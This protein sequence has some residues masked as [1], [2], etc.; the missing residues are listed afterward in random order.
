MR[1]VPRPAFPLSL[2]AVLVAGLAA[3]GPAAAVPAVHAR[4]GAPVVDGVP[5]SGEATMSA[6]RIAWR[7]YGAV[8]ELDARVT[9]DGVPV[10]LD[11]P[12]LDRTT[13][14]SGLLARR[15]AEDLAG[16]PV[17]VLGRPGGPLAAATSDRPEPIP[18]LAE[19]LVYA[20]DSGATVSLEIADRAGEPGFDPARNAAGRVMDAVVASGLPAARLIVRSAVPGDLDVARQRLPGV[21][22]ALVTAAA[23]NA[24]GPALAAGR[25]DAWLSPEWPV[26]AAYVA[27]A[28]GAGRLV[29]PAVLD[30]PA[31]V[32][33]GAALAVDAIVT[34]DLP[35]A[36]RALGL[37]ETAPSG[38][39][40][41]APPRSAGARPAVRHARP[42]TPTRAR[43]CACAGAATATP[44]RRHAGFQAAVRARGQRRAAD[45][46]SA[47]R[48]G[49]PPRS[50]T[51]TGRARAR[52]TTSAS[53]RR[54]RRRPR[55][56]RDRP[57]RRALRRPRQRAAALRL[58]AARASPGA[59]QGAVRVAP[60]AGARHALTFTGRALRV[61]APLSPD[62]GRLQ[63]VLDGR[64][65][66]VSLRGERRRPPGRVRARGAALRLPPRHAALARR[67]AGDRRRGRPR[68]SSRAS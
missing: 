66:T 46:R 40:P 62:G 38:Q 6:L 58:L 29:A 64:R 47:R 5:T 41:P 28:H 49:A 32:Q 39:D 30:T 65:R 11:D 55:P 1:R 21:A 9:A 8:L 19:A 42:A 57:L 50:A 22:T 26:D 43:A 33:A 31:D 53:V 51:F 18:T 17:D 3:A 37:P 4:G 45:W 60:R 59:W 36:R 48:R 35:M 24:G 27:A 68:L 12:S 67:R 61:I 7:R 44:T 56:G 20:R 2:L 23:D 10:L 54:R 14:C 52:P 25:G 63:V 15:T 16:C 34:D 13:P